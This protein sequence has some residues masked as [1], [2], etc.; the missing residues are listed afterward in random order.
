[1]GKALSPNAEL[2]V[3]EAEPPFWQD[4]AVLAQ[5]AEEHRGS[6]QLARTVLG[7]YRGRV[8]TIASGEARPGVTA[9]PAPGH[10]PGHSGWL[11]AAERSRC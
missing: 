3:H 7:G 4:D 5:A 1:V 2:V 10:T 9:I 11:I 6:I 8:R